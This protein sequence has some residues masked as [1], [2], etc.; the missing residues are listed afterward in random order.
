MCVSLELRVQV[1]CSL[2]S[3]LPVSRA[4]LLIAH[5]HGKMANWTLPLAWVLDGV[6][7]FS[8]V[9]FLQSISDFVPELQ[10]SAAIEKMWETDSPPMRLV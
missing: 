10:M 2:A 7:V 9:R 8:I 3:W 5:P 6:P 4:L 1:S